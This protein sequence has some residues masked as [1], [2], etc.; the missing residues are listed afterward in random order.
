MLVEAYAKFAGSN[1]DSVTAYSIYLKDLRAD[2]IAMHTNVSLGY[3]N[4]LKVAE[5]AGQ[6]RVAE[7]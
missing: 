5:S 2:G 1:F 4:N 3:E 7:I 6:A